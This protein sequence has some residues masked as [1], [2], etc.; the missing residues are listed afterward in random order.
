[1]KAVTPADMKAHGRAPWM[2][3]A[4]GGMVVAW[5]GGFLLSSGN[6]RCLDGPNIHECAG[7]FASRAWHD[8][9]LVAIIVGV[10]TV[11]A[12]LAMAA[13]TRQRRG[14]TAH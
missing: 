10:V 11:V 1:M 3:F 7:H 6:D 9:G 2:G 5:A 12:A 4:I 13:H 14:P 8:V